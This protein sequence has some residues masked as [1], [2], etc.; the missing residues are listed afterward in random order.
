MGVQCHDRRH[1][2]SRI[3]WGVPLSWAQAY[4]EWPE[5][6]REFVRDC[7]ELGLTEFDARPRRVTLHSGEVKDISVD[8]QAFRPGDK[9]ELVA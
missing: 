6:V 7:R 8:I 5:K 3:D 9:W 2:P 4:P 1:P